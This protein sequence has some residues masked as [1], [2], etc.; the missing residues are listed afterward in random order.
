[1]HK[2]VPV[3]IPL[4]RKRPEAQFAL[5]RLV[6]YVQ[7]LMRNHIMLPRERFFANFALKRFQIGVHNHV[8][9]VRRFLVKLLVA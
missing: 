6:G 3:K 7:G 4:A 1:M 9:V 5:K 2:S 8:P